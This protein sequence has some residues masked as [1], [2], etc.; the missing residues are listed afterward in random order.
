[1]IKLRK[2]EDR[3]KFDFGWLKTAH[4]FSFGDYHDPAQMHFRNLRVINEDFVQPAEGFDTHGHRDME[5]ITYILEGALEHK[6]SMGTGAVIRPGEVQRMSA[7]SGVSHSEFNASKDKLVH[8]LQIWILPQEK[9][10]KPSYEQTAFSRDERLNKLKLVA[11][12]DGKEG[13]VTINQDVKLYGSILEKGKK[14]HFDIP[15]KRYAW[16]QVARGGVELNGQ[17]LNAGDGAAISD[18]KVLDITANQDSEF[19]L[20]DLN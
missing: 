17:K 10:I 1:M 8:L 13:S 6:D 11:S 19:L 4:T 12:P 18:E 15:P 3:G 16:L 20:F 14:V 7:G 5:I 2:A 9:G